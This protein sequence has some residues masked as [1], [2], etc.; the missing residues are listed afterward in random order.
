MRPLHLSHFL[1]AAVS[2]GMD[3]VQ[4]KMDEAF[5]WAPSSI[6]PNDALDK[7]AT[8]KYL[9]V[10]AERCADLELTASFA[11]VR[12]MQDLLAKP[13]QTPTHST[14]R[15]LSIEFQ[16]RLLDE[17][18]GKIFWSLTARESEFYRHPHKGWEEIIARFP[19]AVSDVEEAHICFALS[20]YAAAIFHSVQIVEMGLIELGKIRWRK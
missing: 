9:K 7:T 6:A 18:Q 3:F 8:D 2:G 12:K 11:T 17:L 1:T 4:G 20:R 14:M 13:D 5:P 16:K 15:P 10:L 19:N